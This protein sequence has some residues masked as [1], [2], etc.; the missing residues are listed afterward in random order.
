M[1]EWGKWWASRGKDTIIKCEFCGSNVP[2]HKAVEVNV[3]MRL[4]SDIY[5]LAEHVSLASK[6]SYCCISCAKH[7]KIVKDGVHTTE[8]DK[9]VK[10][11][12][13]AKREMDKVLAKVS[14]MEKAERKTTKPTIAQG[15]KPKEVAKEPAKK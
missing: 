13:K 14:E 7:R 6:K 9:W 12:A 5:E 8:K 11:K 15:S 2:K 1:G 4:S 3:G 10:K